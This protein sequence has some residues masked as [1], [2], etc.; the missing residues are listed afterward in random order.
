MA[1]VLATLGALKWWQWA[2]LLAVLIAT[3]GATAAFALTGGSRA[4]SLEG[5]E[6]VVPITYGDVMNQVST[7]G[8]LSFPNL[9]A[10]T[11]GSQ[12]TVGAVLVEAGERVEE[13]Q[14]VA[15]LD[16]SAQGSLRRAT[17]QARLDVRRAEEALVKARSPYTALDVAKAESALATAKLSVRRA[18]EALDSLLRP[19]AETLASAQSQA[20][21]A[22]TALAKASLDLLQAQ[23]GWKDRLEA[24]QDR[25]ET[26]LDDYTGV[27]DKYLGIAI[28]PAQAKQDPEALLGSWGA[29]LASLFNPDYRLRDTARGL[30]AQGPSLD[31]PTTPWSEP[32]LY[33]WLNLFPNPIMANCAG[34]EAP[35]GTLC[36][37][38][39]M[40]AAWT[41][42]E[43]AQE[44]WE[45]AQG[46]AA[47]ALAT[48]EATVGRQELSLQN[49]REA[50]VT[51]QGPPD[52]LEAA[53]KEK[54]LALAQATLQDAEERLATIREGAD[55]LQVALEEA[56][57]ASAQQALEA[58]LQRLED[59]TLRAPMAGI[60]ARVLVEPGQAVNPNTPILE[61]VDP[62]VVEMQGL[63]DEVD[64]LFV[65][66]GASASVTLDALPGRQLSGT[67]SEIAFASRSQQGVVTYPAT[68]RIE[69]PS[70]VELLEGLTAF[71]NIVIREER[72]V[73]IVPNAALEGSFEEPM[74]RVLRDGRVVEQAVVLGLSDDAWTAVRQGLAE[75]DQVV[76]RTREVTT[77]P[78][79]FGGGGFRGQGQGGASQV[80]RGNRGQD[81]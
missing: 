58:V 33:A 63:V 24:A 43:K 29:D 68:I 1:G 21:T 35:R 14:E 60:V 2:A 32:L 11:F 45:V 49:A 7:S 46:E 66:K 75:G 19:S 80:L 73:L 50:L 17:A 52:T 54:Q 26:A 34:V 36:I 61:V 69:L 76:M 77:S 20:D 70:D 27:F 4:A 56:D 51:L 23:R 6:Q 25:A 72:G 3:V 30:V 67:V 57:V 64:V 40:D 59:T 65:R 53:E 42:W 48:A 22:A 18:Q 71:A 16:E 78:F 62:R 5:A 13:G 10:L 8:A 55:S 39:E 74:I 47:N 44:D 81:R 79:G 41:A 12:G 38:R 15:R 31:D 28:S 9:F 37:R